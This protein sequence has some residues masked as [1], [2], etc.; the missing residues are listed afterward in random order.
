MLSGS[1]RSCPERFR[2]RIRYSTVR[3]GEFI[4]CSDGSRVLVDGNEVVS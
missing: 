1:C 4:Y 2:C 3:S